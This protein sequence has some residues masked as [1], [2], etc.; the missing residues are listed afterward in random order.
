[1]AQ[2]DWEVYNNHTTKPREVDSEERRRIAVEECYNQMQ[3][4]E[5]IS[6]DKKDDSR[7]PLQDKLLADPTMMGMVNS[8][9]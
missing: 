3:S 5:Y 1:M 9:K 7:N 6:N 4:Q 2:I 8:S